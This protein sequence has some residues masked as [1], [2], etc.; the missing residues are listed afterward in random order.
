MLARVLLVSFG[1]WAFGPKLR[2]VVSGQA[3]CWPL[4]LRFTKMPGL[5]VWAPYTLVRLSVQAKVL[6][7][8]SQ[9]GAKE[10]KLHPVP[11]LKFGKRLRKFASGYNS[12]N[13]NPS[14]CRS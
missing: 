7:S 1:F 13:V 10:E 6:P 11:Q 2:L 5:K 3:G 9:P 4:L 8:L 12:W 14:F